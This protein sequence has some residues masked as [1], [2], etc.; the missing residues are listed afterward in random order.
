[1]TTRPK[2]LA[3]VLV[4]CSL[5]ASAASP[6]AGLSFSHNDWEIACDNTRTCRAAGYHSEEAQLTVSVLLTRQAGPRQV[7]I[8]ELMLGNFGNE[9]LFEKW[10]ASS[11]ESFVLWQFLP[12]IRIV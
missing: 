7:I 8:G 5:S 6:T 2:A 3:T 10:L 12:K 4:L 9:D 11:V 1:M